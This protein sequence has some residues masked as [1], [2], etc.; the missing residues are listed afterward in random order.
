MISVLRCATVKKLQWRLLKGKLFSGH[1]WQK[2][3]HDLCVHAILVRKQVTKAPQISYVIFLY[4]LQIRSLR[5]FQN[6]HVHEVQ[7]DNRQD[8]RKWR[9]VTSIL[10]SSGM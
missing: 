7:G 9:L 3:T 10:R 4:K 6:F 8:L 5:R 1:L 2:Y